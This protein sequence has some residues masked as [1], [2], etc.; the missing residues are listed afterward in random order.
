[1][2]GADKPIVQIDASACLARHAGGDA[3]QAGFSRT[4]RPEQTG[5]RARMGGERYVIENAQSVIGVPDGLEAQLGGN[6]NGRDIGFAPSRSA[7]IYGL[8]MVLAGGHRYS[9]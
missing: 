7:D 5:D 1:M 6:G 8:F 4:R 3:Q 9:I 2:I